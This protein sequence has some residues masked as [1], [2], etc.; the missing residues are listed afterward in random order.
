MSGDEKKTLEQLLA[1]EAA[2]RETPEWKAREA[3]IMAEA[4]SRRKEAEDRVR[5]RQA[6]IAHKEEAEWARDNIDIAK[7]RELTAPKPEP[8]RRK[9]K[10]LGNAIKLAIK[11]LRGGLGSIPENAGERD[12]AINTEIFRTGGYQIPKLDVS[13]EAR[14]K[15]ICRAINELKAQL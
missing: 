3:A 4:L 9:K 7:A 5:A 10:T 2:L 11:T 15:A 8:K 12:N 13:T 1:S 14:K 6:K